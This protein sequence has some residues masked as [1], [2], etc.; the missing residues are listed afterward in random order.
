ME[1]P[2]SGRRRRRSGFQLGALTALGVAL[3]LAAL[4]SVEGQAAPGTTISIA[5]EADTY[6]SA[7]QPATN[8]GAGEFFDTY[9]GF[10]SGCVPH[11][12]PAYGLLRFDL[13]AIPAGAAISSARLVATT[14]AGWAQNGDQNHHAVFLADDSWDESTVTWDT[15][16]DDGTVAPGDPTLTAGG[17]DIRVSSRALG[18]TSV[19]RNTC[20]TDPAGDQTKIFPTNDVDVEKS[21]TAS[22]ADLLSRIATER[23]GDGELSLE[24]YNPNCPACGPG[25]PNAGYWARYWSSESSD[26]SRHP[27]L[28]ITFGPDNDVW[29]RAQPIALDGA[30]NG[31]DIGSIDVSGQARWYR[32]AVQPGTR[33][34]VDLSNLPGNYDVALFT[35]IGQAFNTLTSPADLQRLSAEFAADA[36]SPSVF[37]PSV[38][39]PS[40]FSPSVFSPSVFSPSVFS[41]SVFSPSVFSPSVFSPS[42]FSP[43]VF[44]PSVFSPSVFSPSVFSDG[45]A[46]E[47]AQVRSLIAVSANDGNANEQISI[48]T[49]NNTGNFY[50]RVAG[51]NG[52]YSPAAPFALDVHVDPST[53][54]GVTTS[55]AALLS[56]PAQTGVQTLILADYARMS[57]SLTTM[58]ARLG[59]LAG[60]VGGAIVNLGAAS[61]RVAALN[62]QADAN[63]GCPY[64]K[65]LVADA[66]RD[67]VLAYRAANPGLAN[68]VIVGNDAAVPFFRYP[69]AAGLGPESGYVPPVQNTSA[70]QASL[71]LNYYLSQ[72]AYGALTELQVKGVSLPVPDLPVGRL[73]ETPAE[74][75][76]VIDAFLADGVLD[77]TTSLVTG[78]DFLTDGATSV[79]DA[80]SAGLGGSG[81]DALITNQDVDPADTGTPPLRSW[82]A[83]QLRTSLFGARHD[84]VY[85]AGHF[86]ANNLL[87]ADYATTVNATEL[88]ASSVN[89]AGSLVLSAGCHSGYTIVD[90]EAVPN[91][92]QPLDWVQA[93]AQKR[94]T[95]IAGTGYQ[96]GDTDFLEYSER[97]Y[98]NV[99]QTLRTGTGAVGV[100]RALVTAK[101]RYLADTPTLGGIHQKAVLEATLYG[102]PMAAVNLPA[103][104]NFVPPSGPPI[105]AGT[106]PVTT[107]PGS[108]LG[109]SFADVTRSPTLAPFSRALLN[110]DGTPSGV[111]ATWFAGPSGVVTNPGAPALPLEA[112]DASVA[113]KVL[114]GVGFRG[115][116]FTDVTG[117]TPLTGAPATELN[118]VHSPFVSEAFYPSRLW[119]VNYFG[120]LQGAATST[121]LMLTP[122][123]YRSDAPGSL[124]NTRR[125]F[126]STELQALLQRLHDLVRDEL[127]SSRRSPHDRPGGGDRRGQQRR[128][129]HA[130]R[131]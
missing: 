47:S 114:R 118:S 89:L 14:R 11:T 23:A 44:S 35:D 110:G 119:S 20:L 112:N 19:F 131:G 83:D 130:G 101:Q 72:D 25:G 60:A 9:G 106:T 53:C 12:A 52:A 10:N 82:T 120:G 34:R 1:G 79:Q 122:V 26:P 96:Y 13:S 39:S 48:D 129:H 102:L 88:A 76:G 103:G 97:L 113:G 126:S 22:H 68:V 109:L 46:Y 121:S 124:T 18:A 6:V 62:T 70:S 16:P 55:A 3:V 94:A 4:T 92:T 100:G 84:I 93:F 32:F 36:F 127:R 28:E 58:Q 41:P 75:T 33:A 74:I 51:R 115:G 61:P 29:T 42:V 81:A 56:T 5:P 111:S 77:P 128:L 15:R 49:W 95:L 30:G 27:R 98:R 38:F 54:T 63:T 73:V 64:A 80:L 87:A 85:L 43:S 24:L 2:T 104:R 105:V 7:S 67:V 31:S 57:G 21:F 8:F 107:N 125:T 50:V 59:T 69:D 117:V 45:Q 17:G 78:Y 90:G 40:V 65:N 66:I 91:V 37:S 116:S 108:T 71:R 99:A 123:Q 86:S